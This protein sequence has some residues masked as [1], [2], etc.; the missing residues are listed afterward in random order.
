MERDQIGC[1]LWCS[2]SALFWHHVVKGSN[3]ADSLLR[4]HYEKYI[5]YCRAANIFTYFFTHNI[6]EINQQWIYNLKKWNKMKL[7]II[8]LI[9]TDT[10]K[11]GRTDR[12][13]DGQK[14]GWTNW[15][16]HYK[17]MFI[18]SIYLFLILKTN[19]SIQYFYSNINSAI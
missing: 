6:V 14:K 4:R 7:N 10:R 8:G 12:W 5:A 1:C 2:L 16:T 18:K 11:D 19:F 3:R 13:T 9:Y 17:D 15:W